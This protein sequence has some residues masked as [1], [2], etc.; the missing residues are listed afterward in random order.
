MRTSPT[1]EIVIHAQRL[2]VELEQAVVAFPRKHKYLLGLDLR[3]WAQQANMLTQRT[4]RARAHKLEQA[5][6]VQLLI[7]EMDL[8]K[9]GL[10]TGDALQC[11][12][13]KGCF[14]SL[15]KLAAGVGRQAGGWHKEIAK[16]LNGQSPAAEMPL[17]RPEILSTAA[18]SQGA[19]R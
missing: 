18:A 4:W 12:S 1:P 13:S 2:M 14:E 11:F 7:D 3:R 8:L 15:A 16:H 6:L 9:L 5:R 17:E 19:Q 10:Q